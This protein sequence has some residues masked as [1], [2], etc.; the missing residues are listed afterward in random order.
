MK[1]IFKAT[2]LSLLT[3][4]VIVLLCSCGFNIL[5]LDTVITP[6]TEP[7]EHTESTPQT[8]RIEVPAQTDEAK[9]TASTE[10]HVHSWSQ[11]TL[12]AEPTCTR[13]GE[14]CRYCD[15]GDSESRSLRILDHNIVT[16][17]GYAP[18]CTSSGLS[19]KRHCS[20]CDFILVDHTELAPLEHTVVIDAAVEATCEASGLTEGSHCS[21][22]GVVLVYQI[23]T[24]KIPHVEISIPAV[25]PTCTEDGLTEGKCCFHCGT[26]TVAQET[27]MSKGHT[28]QL[29]YSEPTWD[30]QGMNITSC[31]VCSH[32][33]YEYT[34]AAYRDTLYGYSQ[35]GTLYNASGYQGLYYAI[36]QACETV[37]KST[38]SYS[39]STDYIEIN[40]SDYGLTLDQAVSVWKI[41]Y[42]EN[43][44]Y[45]WMA[46]M[47]GY[48]DSA[49][50]IY[51]DSLYYSYSVRKQCNAD[52]EAMITECS[53]AVLAANSEYDKVLAIHDYINGK[54]EYAYDRSGAPETSQWAHN[55]IGVASKDKG[56][57]E[58]YA[59]TFLFLCRVYGIDCIIITGFSNGE[60]HAWNA[61]EIDG[62][63][64]YADLTWNDGAGNYYY[65][66]LS[67][68][69]FNQSHT[70][71]GSVHGIDYL[72]ELPTISSF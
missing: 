66:G 38:K 43:P 11:W 32:S 33:E 35:F 30:T 48:S 27:V 56:V 24:S 69:L 42:I 1:T 14:E 62:N 20:T 12:V 15:C 47:V 54:I 64:Y 49:I 44:K 10:R 23:S 57:C 28:L 29:S 68:Y 53:V 2:V 22:C 50:C 51:I 71:D 17:E 37:H 40:T 4:V 36:Y 59:K 31:L 25:A 70:T 45:Y 72:Y 63:W 18:S 58:S 9:D 19:E 8:D 67:P 65:F 7:N 41:F 46:N 21:T 39:N 13:A 61:V 16:E 52:I 55:I 3:A 26:I 60:G 5:N 34:E 6:L